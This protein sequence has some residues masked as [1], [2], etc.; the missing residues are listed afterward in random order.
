MFAGR[1]E[2]VQRLEQALLQARAGQP[3]HFML[4]GERGIGKSSLLL[5]LRYV[6]NGAI[7]LGDQKLSFLILDLDV[8]GETTQLGL[9]Q[10]VELALQKEL[11]KT[12]PARNF[13]KDAWSFL[14]R[15]SIMETS[16]SEK[17]ACESAEL[18]L[19]QFA[20]TIAE[21]V[22]RTCSENAAT[23]FNAKYDGILVLIDE[24]DNCGADLQLGSF[25]KLFL[26]RLQKR[27]CNRVLIGLAGLPE[28]RT[29]LHA[30]HPSSLRIFEEMPLERLSDAEVSSVIDMCLARAN[31]DNVEKT[32][33]DN[34]AKAALIGLA[35]GYPHFAQ[36]FGYSAFA[37]DQDG[38]IDSLDVQRSAFGPRGALELIGDRYYRNDFYNKIQKDTYR[39]VL[40]IM[41]DDL[42]A[43]V[44][45]DKI[46]SKFKGN[47]TTLRNALQALRTR[48]IILSKEGEKGVY[49]LQHKG[50][51]LWI[52][53]YA[54]PNFFQQLL[55]NPPSASPP[56]SAP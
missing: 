42:D 15:V 24:A 29:K 25:L 17:R 47:D 28:L 41:A 11:G 51:A 32:S 43:W 22:E 48:H 46:R 16:I 7:A 9:V 45:R 13:L 10:R 4:T 12:E 49:R 8:N 19:D 53:F 20:Y 36:Q 34:E 5:Y 18:L 35:E 26:E 27:A 50:F 55:T 52:R 31:V 30:S 33:I 23:M 54:D 21:V 40:R 3:A 38:K 2:E 37:A 56:P 1:L 39:Q 14:Q 44:T 6:A